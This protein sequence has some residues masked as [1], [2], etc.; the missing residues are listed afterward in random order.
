MTYSKESVRGYRLLTQVSPS[1]SLF[2]LSGQVVP[3]QVA[4]FR[5][6]PS[7]GAYGTHEMSVELQ[8]DEYLLGAS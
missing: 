3:L 7:L 5:S 6:A 8:R 2:V 4:P 1:L